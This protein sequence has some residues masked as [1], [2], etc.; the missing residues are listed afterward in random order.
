MDN[1]IKT[2]VISGFIWQFAESCGA[3][4]VSFIV[5]IIL[6]RILEPTDYGTISLLLVFI[7]ILNVFVDSGLGNALVQKKDADD[8]GFSTVFIFNIFMC[9]TLYA[10]MFLCAPAIAIFYGDKSLVA[11]IR[12]LSIIIL[13]S[14]VKNVQKAYVSKHMYFKKFFF[15]TLGGTICSAFI[16][17]ILAYSGFGVWALVIQQLSNMLIDT[18]VL[19]YIVKWKPQWIFSLTRLKPLLLYGW[20]LLLARLL[21]TVYNNLTQLIIGKQFSTADLAYYNRGQQFP[22]LI[23]SNVNSSIDGVLFPVMSK[24]QEDTYLVRK[25]TQ[26]AITVSSFVM[27]PMMIG[28]TVI[29]EPLVRFVLT[30]KWLEC[31]PYLQIFCLSYALYPI[32]TAN[33]NA[34]KALGRSDIF[35][36]LELIKKI[37]GI[38]IIVVGISFGTFGLAIAILISSIIST[39]IN[40]YPNKKKLDY[41][42]IQQIKDILPSIIMSLI[43]GAIVYPIKF[44]SINSVIIVILQVI[45]GIIVYI[46]E[47]KIIKS[48]TY[49][50]VVGIIKE[51]KAQMRKNG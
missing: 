49:D 27:W 37:I 40:A 24:E 25:M 50:F 17:I 38:L 31:V 45:A 30:D 41:S 6:A 32:H 34:I 48:N 11:L 18:I 14:G 43:M 3:Q 36:K 33:L 19:W 39:F 2:K 42:Y 29:A 22:N 4:I 13:I 8:A 9:I 28:L 26:R 20:K 51:K 21:D 23:V 44:L 1:K 16:G 47:A 5:S 12:V 35:L 7:T 10:I 46:F 15:A